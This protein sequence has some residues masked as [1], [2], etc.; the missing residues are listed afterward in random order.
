MQQAAE[1]YGAGLSV[2]D[3]DAINEYINTAGG[4]FVMGAVPGGVGGIRTRMNAPAIQAPAE[5]PLE[6][7]QQEIAPPEAPPPAAPLA[8]G[9]NK[10]FTPQ[11][12]PDGSVALTQ[13]DLDAY[14]Q[15]QFEAKYAPQ[16]NLN[17]AEVAATPPQL[18]YSCL[19]YTSD[20]ADE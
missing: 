7:P 18:G 17:K 12:L 1:R 5:V 10:P 2:N 9:M 3:K 13:A 19:L 14:N 11:A 20:A 6:V 15:S 8:L 16:P 4:A